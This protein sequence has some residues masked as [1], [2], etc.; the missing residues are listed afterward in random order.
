MCIELYTKLIG[1]RKTAATLPEKKDYVPA[2]KIEIAIKYLDYLK[3]MDQQQR[4]RCD[5]I[6]NKNSL[7]VGQASI[8]ISIISL[9]VPLLIDKFIQLNIVLIVFLLFIFLIVL[10]HYLLSIIHSIRTL[11]IDKYPYVTRSVTSVTRDNRA[12]NELDFINEEILDLVLSLDQNT[13][14][15]NRKGGNL[16]YAAR[17]FKIGNIFFSILT[18][19]VIGSSFALPYE[20]KPQEIVVRNFEDLKFF[21]GDTSRNDKICKSYWDTLIIKIDNKGFG[22]IYKNE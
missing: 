2:S 17:C 7:M 18:V 6:E 5:T 19:V 10:W 12:S 11:L 15:N 21:K 22:K 3:E 14:M 4:G 8:V 9:F 20:N 13:E 1:L 16:I